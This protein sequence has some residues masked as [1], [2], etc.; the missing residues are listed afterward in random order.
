[1]IHCFHSALVI[2][3]RLVS[4][5]RPGRR[6]SVITINPRSCACLTAFWTVVRAT[7]ALAAIS[8]IEQSHCLVQPA[9]DAMIANAASSP[10][11]K[12]AARE[13]GMTPAVARV[14]RR[15][16]DFAR[17][18]E[19]CCRRAGKRCRGRGGRWSDAGCEAPPVCTATAPA[20]RM[21]MRRIS[22]WV[23]S[24]SA[25]PSAMAPLP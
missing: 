5:G 15:A 11:V 16:M 12:R 18:G 2:R 9:S 13:G 22:A 19:R 10:V 7:P 24:C 20:P 1:M 14:R 23:A 8:A 4:L 17:S 25:S 6:R 3:I 21:E